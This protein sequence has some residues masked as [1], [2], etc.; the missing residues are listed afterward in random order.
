[1]TNKIFALIVALIIPVAVGFSASQIASNTV[2]IYGRLSLPLFAPP[3]YVF[4][5]AWTILYLMMGLASYYIYFSKAIKKLKIKAFI[6]YFLQLGINFFWTYFFFVLEW[7]LFAFFWLLLLI[8]VVILSLKYFWDIS[9]IAY[10]L[11]IP[12][13]FWLIFAGYLNLSIYILN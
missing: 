2:E 13:F 12:Y 10:C 8:F 5:I 11:F 3:S 4:G 7:R 6:L 9:K 1:M